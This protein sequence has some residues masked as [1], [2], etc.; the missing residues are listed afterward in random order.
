MTTM[1]ETFA[2]RR[3]QNGVFVL[4]PE[5]LTSRSFRFRAEPRGQEMSPAL[6]FEQG[7]AVAGYDHP[8][9]ARWTIDGGQ[10]LILNFQG[11][12]TCIMSYAGQTDGSVALAGIFVDPTQPDVPT[13]VVHWLFENGEQAEA[14]ET[15]RIPDG[16]RGAI[17]NDPTSAESLSV[18]S[19]YTPNFEPMLIRFVSGI[20]DNVNCHCYNLDSE[21]VGGDGGGKKVWQFK[22]ERLIH[23]SDPTSNHSDDIIVFADIDIAVYDKMASG[24]KSALEG[25]DIVFQ[26]ETGRANDQANIGVIAFRRS[27]VVSRFWTDVLTIVE[28]TSNW[29]QAVVNELIANKPYL[30]QIGLRTGFLPSEFWAH[31]QGVFLPLPHKC[32]LH[33]ANC[34]STIDGKWL[35]LNA[36]REL[37]ESSKSRSIEAFTEIKRLLTMVVWS[38]G[39][40]ALPGPYGNIRFDDALYVKEYNNFNEH[41]LVVRDES[42]IMLNQDGH[43]SCKFNEFYMDRARK[44]VMAVG[45]L[46]RQKVLQGDQKPIFHYLIAS[47]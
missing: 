7:G 22:T 44:R 21:G 26:R 23:C 37:F 34:I 33:H 14:A 8:N 25:H 15:N 1:P 40:L 45:V 20:A 6:R 19:F 24:L 11:Q 30:R 47:F 41:R 5:W 38:F 35:Q 42:L 39:N 10:L 43:I 16:Q 32:V 46:F 27:T 18:F 28:Q 17:V 3:T 29:D 12:P 36:Y 9:E 2:D 4:N 13:N 31:S